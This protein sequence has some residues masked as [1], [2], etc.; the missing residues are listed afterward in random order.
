MNVGYVLDG[1][2][3]SLSNQ[4]DTCRCR[5]AHKH[6]LTRAVVIKVDPFDVVCGGRAA[7]AAMDEEDTRFGS[8]VR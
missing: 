2:V 4:Q 6:T 7:A 5:G 8:T 3:L 1:D